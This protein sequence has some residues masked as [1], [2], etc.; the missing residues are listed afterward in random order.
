MVGG[1]VRRVGMA[2]FAYGLMYAV[3]RLTTWLVYLDVPVF[4]IIPWLPGWVNFF[5]IWNLPGIAMAVLVLIGKPERKYVLA[6][7]AV[8]LS[9]ALWN[10]YAAVEPFP[11]QPEVY[12]QTAA[13][14][15]FENCGVFQTIPG[16]NIIDY[17]WTVK[18]GK[19]CVFY[20][21]RPEPRNQYIL[22]IKDGWSNAQ[23]I[24]EKSEAGIFYFDHRIMPAG[25]TFIRLLKQGRLDEKSMHY[26]INNDYRGG[27]DFVAY[28]RTY[29]DDFVFWF[30]SRPA[31]NMSSTLLVRL[32]VVIEARR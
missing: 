8:L 27:N 30:M 32:H 17:N 24:R 23:V 26:S 12:L 22:R 9:A 20:I 7:A 13:E 11:I 29:R 19:W 25:T 18:A 21:I 16:E 10:G 31:D 6:G 4:R 15:G 5:I 1:L 3:I 28:G 2:L 14:H